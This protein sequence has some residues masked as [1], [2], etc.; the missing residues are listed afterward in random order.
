VA[1]NRMLKRGR[2]VLMQ[3]EEA[4]LANVSKAAG[5]SGAP[6]LQMDP[7]PQSVSQS[8][9]TQPLPAAKHL[10]LTLAP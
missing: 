5:A 10:L 4:V 9:T 3:E 8:G 2:R 1:S 7:T 6:Q